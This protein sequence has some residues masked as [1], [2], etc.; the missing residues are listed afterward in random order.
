MNH[1]DDIQYPDSVDVRWVQQVHSLKP[2]LQLKLRAKGLLPYF[3][4]PDTNKI[5]YRRLDVEAYIVSGKVCI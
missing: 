5:L 4:L 2:G 1:V 3:K